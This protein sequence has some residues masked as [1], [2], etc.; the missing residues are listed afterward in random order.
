MGWNGVEREK[1]LIKPK[2]TGGPVGNGALHKQS[3]N[4]T[5]AG[6]HWAGLGDKFVPSGAW[7]WC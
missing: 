7:E 3:T 5:S 1:Q 2:E 6:V 4:E